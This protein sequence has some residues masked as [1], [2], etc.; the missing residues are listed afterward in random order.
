MPSRTDTVDRLSE[1]CS[2]QFYFWLTWWILP[3][4]M[5]NVCC[6][7]FSSDCA[8][9]VWLLWIRHITYHVVCRGTEEEQLLNTSSW[10]W[11][12]RDV[13]V[14]II[15]VSTWINLRTRTIHVNLSF[16]FQWKPN[17]DSF[18]RLLVDTLVRDK[19]RWEQSLNLEENPPEVVFLSLHSGWK[20]PRFQALHPSLCSEGDA[21]TDTIRRNSLSLCALFTAWPAAPIMQYGCKKKGNSIL[22]HSSWVCHKQSSCSAPSLCLWVT[23][24]C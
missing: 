13:M 9:I 16:H 22:C 3:Q 18:K 17:A 23:P 21:G 5:E 14:N 12:F 6:V 19:I 4:F 20:H 7:W 11:V 24:R 2:E 10:K 8:A 1:L 15:A